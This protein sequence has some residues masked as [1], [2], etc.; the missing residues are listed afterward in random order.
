MEDKDEL[1]E[2]V[3]K[4]VKKGKVEEFIG[5]KIIS[6]IGLDIKEDYIKNYLNEICHNNYNKIDNAQLILFEDNSA[7]CF[8]DFDNDGY[9]S[10]DWN[11]IKL[12]NVL[13]KGRTKEIKIVNSIC[14]DI[15]FFGDVNE[16]GGILITTD[17]YIIKMG[18]NHS[19]AYYPRNFFSVE[20]CKSFALGEG[21][22]IE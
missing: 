2:V 1:T 8:V 19:D 15:E 6:I 5:K 14:K 13:D 20:V 3:K 21:E 11:I 17:E 4:K 16:E 10:G 9:R 7:L 12:K 22:L 18:Q